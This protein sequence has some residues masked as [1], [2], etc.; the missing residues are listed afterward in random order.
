[1]QALLLTRLRRALPNAAVLH[2][3]HREELR[4]MHDRVLQ[5][6]GGVL[7]ASESHGLA[8]LPLHTQYKHAA[9]DTNVIEL[10]PKM[11]PSFTS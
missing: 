3:G 9:A 10:G 7:L 11:T 4:S 6:Q 5:L 1:M 8:P 2:A